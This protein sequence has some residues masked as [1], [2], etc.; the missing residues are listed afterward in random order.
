M[1]AVGGFLVVS[2]V[3]Y[4]A[5]T[6]LRVI[7]WVLGIAVVA[8]VLFVGFHIYIGVRRMR[9]QDAYYLARDA[10]KVWTAMNGKD[11]EEY[12]AWL[13]RKRGYHVEVTA[14]AG[15]HG[16]DLLLRKDGAWYAV[17]AKRY[18]MHNP[19]R[20]KEVREFYGSY[21]N[22]GYER[23]FFVTTGRFTDAARVWPGSRSLTLVNGAELHEMAQG[24]EGG[25]LAEMLRHTFS[26]K[27]W[28]GIV[29]K[30]DTGVR[31]YERY[32]E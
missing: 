17:Q 8:L 18:G 3:A 4:Y 28:K 5:D 14:Y 1:Y 15:D 19:V 20:E 16:I 9:R 24:L 29:T 22:L 13:F 31:D 2:V 11:F 7:P 21:A 6:I 23:G 12:L 26:S 25:S 30:D 32:R 10:E 27:W